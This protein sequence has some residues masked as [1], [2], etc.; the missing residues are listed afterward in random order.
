[1]ASV[2]VVEIRAQVLDALVRGRRDVSGAHGRDDVDSLSRS[3]DGDVEPPPSLRLVQNA[4]VGGD[5]ARLVRAV[6][7]GE[8][9]DVALVSLDRLKGLDEEGVEAVG[10][11]EEPVEVAPLL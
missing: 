8:D 11:V 1:M 5:L 2:G 7:D 4:E 10:A 6:A 9:D 3:G